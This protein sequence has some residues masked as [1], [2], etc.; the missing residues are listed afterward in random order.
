MKRILFVDDEPRVLEALKRML[1]PLRHE[2][3]SEFA[4]SGPEALRLLSEAEYD[5]IVTDVR[6]AGMSGIELLQEV[7]KQFPQVVRMVLSGTADQE[8]TLRSATLAHQYLM[9]P[10][11][12]ATLHATVER[13][14]RLRSMLEDAGLKKLISRIRS[15]P[16]I[17][18]VYANLLAALRSPDIST[19]EIGDI[20]SRDISMTAK[21]LQLVNSAFF[22]ISRNVT[23][24]LTAA[25]YLGTE[26]IRALTLTIS[27]FS[28]FDIQAAST[29]SIQT[30]HDHSLTVGA[31]ARGIAKSMGLPKTSSDDA[32]TGGLLHDVGRLV[33]AC[34]CPE[35]YEQVL[36]II[37]KDELASRTAEFQVFG[38]SHSEVGAYLLWLWGLPD[39]VTEIVAHHHAPAAVQPPPLALIAVH[40]ADALV[41][42]SCERDLDMAC[43]NALGL[44][45][46]LPEWK[47]MHDDLAAE[48]AA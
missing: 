12:A 7:V 36:R 31:L 33:L 29:F 47:R 37:K 4:S 44:A 35:Q 32:F 38:T 18:A 17:P 25:I 28:Q 24:P 16:S 34:N 15:L 1:Y 45:A 6:M 30:L 42:G 26:T 22:G 23:N 11:D 5:V 41:N 27:V 14:F 3:H 20:I 46:R 13:A 48:V 43:L 10:C 8:I 2:W 39:P 19:K 21:I 40:V 9:K